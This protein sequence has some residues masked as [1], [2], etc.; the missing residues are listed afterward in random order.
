LAPLSVTD[1]ASGGPA[2]R[3]SYP[4]C[5]RRSGCCA[6]AA[7]QCGIWH[8][9]VGGPAQSSPAPCRRSSFRFLPRV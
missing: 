1:G 5:R 4:Q 8:G 3:A 2:R 7:V 6:S 9:G